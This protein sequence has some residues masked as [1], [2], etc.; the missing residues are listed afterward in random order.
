M[1]NFLKQIS[2]TEQGLYA[3]HQELYLILKRLGVTPEQHAQ[4]LAQQNMEEDFLKYL[5]DT[6]LAIT[7][8]L[9]QRS[10]SRK[11]SEKIIKIREHLN[12]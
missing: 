9:L 3:V 2:R 6:G 8:I 5:K 10:K 11:E 4:K 1:F 12:Q 7:T